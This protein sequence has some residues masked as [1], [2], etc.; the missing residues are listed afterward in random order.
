MNTPQAPHLRLCV[1]G[2]PKLKTKTFPSPGHRFRSR[3]GRASVLLPWLPACSGGSGISHQRPGAAAELVD[4]QKS[5]QTFRHSA[6]GKVM[7]S[8]ASIRKAQTLWRNPRTRSSENQVLVKR[9][10][11]PAVRKLPGGFEIAGA[12]EN[13]KPERNADFDG[14]R[15]GHAFA[16][17]GRGEGFRVAS[18]YFRLAGEFLGGL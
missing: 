2:T 4:A 11:L 6:N 15:W 18:G 12:G 14:V 5:P 3:P 13:E 17:A 10:C 1:C 8:Q 7:A 9:R 16:S